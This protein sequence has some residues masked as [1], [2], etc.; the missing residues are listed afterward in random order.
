MQFHYDW[1][2]YVIIHSFNGSHSILPTSSSVNPT[3][4]QSSGC[5]VWHAFF[6]ILGIL[7]ACLFLHDSVCDGITMG[8]SPNKHP[9]ERQWVY[10]WENAYHTYIHAHNPIALHMYRRNFCLLPLWSSHARAAC[11]TKSHSQRVFNPPCLK[12]LLVLAENAHTTA[13]TQT[14]SACL[15]QCSVIGANWYFCVH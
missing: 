4:T 5:V 1:R 2:F 14:E 11:V 13:Y 6:V 9:L 7:Q 8:S 12:G 10:P 15:I 3:H